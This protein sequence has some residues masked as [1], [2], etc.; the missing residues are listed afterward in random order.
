MDTQKIQKDFP[1]LLSKDPVVYLDSSATSLTPESVLAV[2]D[3]YYRTYRANIHRGVYREAERATNEYEEAR[4]VVAQF[5]GAERDEI[6]FTAG[7]TASSNILF[8]SLEQMGFLREGDEVVTSAM[9]HH[10][11]LLPLQRFVKNT[12]STMRFI[13]LGVD[14]SLAYENLDEVITEKT[15]LVSIMLVSNV[16]GTINDVARIAQRAHE[17]GALVVVDATAGVGHM[18]VDAKEL[19]ADFMFFSGHKMCGPTGIGVLYGKK[20]ELSKLEPSFIGGGIVE[21]VTR[22]RA[23]LCEGP[24]KFEAGTPNIAGIIG[25]KEAVRYVSKI[26]L[27]NIQKHSQELVSYAQEKITEIEGVSIFSAPPK[28]NVGIVSFTLTNVH[29]HDVA[30]VAGKNRIALRAGHHCAMP[31]HTALSLS[32]TT[33]ASIY[34]YNTKTD[35]DALVA[36]VEEVTR[37]FK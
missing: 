34:F 4:D 29:P 6:I 26:G 37:L 25:L 7:A 3:E 15:K 13:E 9:E 16:L 14:F 27:E 8:Q 32:G 31:L 21:D 2:M 12:K 1:I 22:T 10:A 23:L 30:S 35:I 11:V 24:E 5:I 36:S 28:N 19:G 17:V 18:L 33:R 20:E